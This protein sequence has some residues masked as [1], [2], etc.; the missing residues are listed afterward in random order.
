MQNQVIIEHLVFYMDL[1]RTLA[2][3][4]NPWYHFY[5]EIFL[6]LI[7][8][9][10]SLDQKSMCGYGSIFEGLNIYIEVWILT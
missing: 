3:H 2:S 8:E 10:L 7:I 5:D 4:G 9:I 6:A 1:S